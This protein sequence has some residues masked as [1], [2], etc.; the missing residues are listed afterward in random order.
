MRVGAD[1]QKAKLIAKNEV[2]GLFK[3]KDDPRVTQFGK[4]LRRTGIDELPQLI[5]IFR[6]EMAVV[7]PRPHLRIELDNFKGWRRARFKVKPGL[8]GMW[9]VNGRH[10]L[11]FDKAVLYDVYYT[12][13]MSFFTDVSIILKTVPAI[14]MNKGRF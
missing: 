14:I 9:Q 2:K 1:D 8:T 11:N 10:E 12:K 4:L 5:N 6:G 13:H 7:G 3:L